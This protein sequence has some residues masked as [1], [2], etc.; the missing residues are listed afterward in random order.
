MNRSLFA[1]VDAAVGQALA[2]RPSKLDAIDLE[3]WTPDMLREDAAAVNDTIEMVCVEHGWSPDAY[4][5]TYRRLRPTRHT[6]S[7]AS[8]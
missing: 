8:Y 7:T 6:P 1:Q 3:E 5:R 2:N 4:N